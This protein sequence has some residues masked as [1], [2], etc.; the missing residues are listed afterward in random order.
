VKRW[1]LAISIAAAIAAQAGAKRYSD[2]ELK[3]MF[4]YRPY[5]QYPYAFRKRHI[6]GSG[7]FRMYVDQAGT[8]TAIKVLA[9]T[10]HH[11]LDVETPRALIRWR[12]RPGERREVDMPVT[13][14]MYG[15]QP[16]GLAY[17]SVIQGSQREQSRR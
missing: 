4:T 10:G 17:D 14:T 9:S 6:T 13:F 12:A 11:G 7:W 16:K 8:V 5:P 1:L 15:F 3:A 2:A